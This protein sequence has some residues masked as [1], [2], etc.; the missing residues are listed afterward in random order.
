M[1]NESKIIDAAHAVMAALLTVMEHTRGESP[2]V[3]AVLAAIDRVERC[4]SEMTELVLAGDEAVA[5]AAA[6]HHCAEMLA[7]GIAYLQGAASGRDV[8]WEEKVGGAP[9]VS[10]YD[11]VVVLGQELSKC[12][13]AST[14]PLMSTTQLDALDA[15]NTWILTF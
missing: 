13:W 3:S 14:T 11:H 4:T 2:D 8:Y 7:L 12:G 5:V 9:R 1:K 10:E 6:Q 15:Y